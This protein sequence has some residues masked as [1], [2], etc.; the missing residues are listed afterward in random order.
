M[1]D[2]SRDDHQRDDTKHTYEMGGVLRR[3]RTHAGRAGQRQRT[4]KPHQES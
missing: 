4:Y 3:Y 1:W 2:V